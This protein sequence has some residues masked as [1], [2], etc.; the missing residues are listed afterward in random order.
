[1]HGLGTQSASF[2]ARCFHCLQIP[3]VSIT[4]RK[5]IAR[6]HRQF[7]AVLKMIRF[8]KYLPSAAQQLH[9][10]RNSHF[11]ENP[12]WPINTEH[13]SSFFCNVRNIRWYAFVYTSAAV[14][15]CSR[16]DMKNPAVAAA[17]QMTRS[18]SGR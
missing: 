10:S 5:S 4:D 13:F 7:G 16:L 12:N 18:L 14:T 9:L 1:M 6:L 11:R 2:L 8:T 17:G 15:R 3:N